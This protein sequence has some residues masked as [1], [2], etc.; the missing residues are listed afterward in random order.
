MIYLTVIL[1]WCLAILGVFL[2]DSIGDVLCHRDVPQ[3]FRILAVVLWP[4]TVIILA[5]MY[6]LMRTLFRV[7]VGKWL[8]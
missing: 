4:V 6:A 7:Y 8:G 1:L 2:Y 3:W 5:C